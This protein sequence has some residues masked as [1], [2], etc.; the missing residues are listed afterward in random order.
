[1]SQMR[2]TLI[3]EF[4]TILGFTSENGG[5]QMFTCVKRS[6][7]PVL[8]QTG[9]RSKTPSGASKILLF[10]YT[11]THVNF[12]N[13]INECKKWYTDMLEINWMYICT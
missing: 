4:T 9:G 1:M 10:F 13:P 5:Q 7:T 12:I 11:Q 2:R 8:E 6:L 3:I